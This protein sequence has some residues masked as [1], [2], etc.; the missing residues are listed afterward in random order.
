M[1]ISIAEQAL[2]LARRNGDSTSVS[3][4]TSHLQAFKEGKLPTER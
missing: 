1:A 4:L 3:L 2:E